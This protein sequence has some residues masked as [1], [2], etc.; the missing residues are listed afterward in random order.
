[1]KLSEHFSLAE[2]TRS[3]TAT[4]RGIDN[5]PSSAVIENLR[6]LCE[7]VLEPLRQW[8]GKPITISSGYRCPELNKVVGGAKNSQH[9]TGEAADLQPPLLSPRGEKLSDSERIA[10]LKQWLAYIKS[11]LPHDQLILE[12]NSPTSKTFWIHVACKRN[13]NKNRGQVIVGLV[14]TPKNDKK[15]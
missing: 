4:A 1:M 8:Y 3:A 9:M 11:H 12:R 15:V 13:V 14:K 7:K 2:F 6:N 10:I 5:T